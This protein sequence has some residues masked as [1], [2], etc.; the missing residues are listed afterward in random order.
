MNHIYRRIWNHAKQCWVV[1]SE[2]SSARGKRASGRATAHGLI[3]LSVIGL[4][5]AGV[6]ASEV[7][8]QVE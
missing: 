8:E 6:A 3:V 5:P 7:Q 1:G 4:V 2:L